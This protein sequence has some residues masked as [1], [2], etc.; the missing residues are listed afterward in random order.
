MLAGVQQDTLAP[1]K[2]VG[3]FWE[4]AKRMLSKA[5]D[6][7]GTIASVAST[8]IPMLLAEDLGNEE[9]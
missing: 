7:R 4:G 6:N 9:A 3:S 2:K 1:P 5:W 8:V